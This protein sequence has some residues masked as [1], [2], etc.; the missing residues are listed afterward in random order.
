MC[1]IPP[2]HLHGNT[3][4]PGHG[5]TA[6]RSHGDARK[7]PS[8]RDR[9]SP[10]RQHTGAGGL[11]KEPPVQTPHAPAWP[12]RPRRWRPPPAKTRGISAKRAIGPAAPATGATHPAVSPSA[13]FAL[14]RRAGPRNARLGPSRDTRVPVR[15][16]SRP[17]PRAPSP[18][19]DGMPRRQR[20]AGSPFCRH[21]HAGRT[22]RPRAGRSCF[23]PD[24]LHLSSSPRT[25]MSPAPLPWTETLVHEG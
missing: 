17:R 12:G 14:R 23:P 15:R 16:T 4:P 6:R 9:R 2:L 20:A 13:C 7:G 22:G 1:I 10:R 24:A 5:P 25:R 21:V 3:A 18:S 11:P 8:R 19:P